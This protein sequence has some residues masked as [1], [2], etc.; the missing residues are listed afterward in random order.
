MITVTLKVRQH[1]WHPASLKNLHILSK[2]QCSDELLL[3]P[4][5]PRGGH[6]VLEGQLRRI[7]HFSTRIRY[8]TN[9]ISTFNPSAFKIIR[10]GDVETNPGDETVNNSSSNA[11]SSPKSLR[12]LLLNARSLRNKVL[13][14]QVLLLED[15]APTLILILI[16]LR[17]VSI[18]SFYLVALVS[19]S[20]GKITTLK[21]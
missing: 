10:S 14:L 4:S 13:D 8:H 21:R 3:L 5:G 7:K 20:P 1:L 6:L 11:G 15:Y 16:I 12:C 18:L 17:L 19:L 9:E 2:W